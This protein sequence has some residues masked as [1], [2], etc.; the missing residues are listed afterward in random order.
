MLENMYKCV[1][2]MICI[3]MQGFEYFMP[4]YFSNS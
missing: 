1:N 4:I 3:S 2:S